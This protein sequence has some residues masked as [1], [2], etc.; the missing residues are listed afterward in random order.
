MAVTIATKLLK[1]WPAHHWRSQ[2]QL[3]YSNCGPHTTS[4]HN[5]NWTTQAVARTPLTIT[6]A[7]ELLKLWAAH[8]W[9][10]QLQLN[11]YS[12]RRISINHALF[13]MSL[14]SPTKLD[15]HQG[16]KPHQICNVRVLLV[17][18]G[19][20]A[21]ILRPNGHRSKKQSLSLSLIY[22]VRCAVPSKPYDGKTKT[23]K[24]GKWKQNKMYLEEQN[25]IKKERMYCL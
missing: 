14:I 24:K 19:G 15:E 7:T 1:L 13:F 3:N 17:E 10:S 12:G 16:A 9:R 4:D 5:S 2:S 21:T 20:G 18:G 6:I 8:H 23:E 25:K 11:Y 22:C